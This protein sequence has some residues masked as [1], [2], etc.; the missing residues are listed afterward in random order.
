M[1]RG[2]E[3]GYKILEEHLKSGVIKVIG[4]SEYIGIAS[5]GEEVALGTFGM[6]DNLARYLFARPTPDKW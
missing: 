5:D 2:P 1:K 6:E 3:A 4:C